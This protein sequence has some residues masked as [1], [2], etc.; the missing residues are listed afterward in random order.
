MSKK[1]GRRWGYH[2]RPIYI[3]DVVTDNAKH[4]LFRWWLIMHVLIPPF[5]FSKRGLCQATNGLAI[6]RKIICFYFL[7]GMTQ[8]FMVG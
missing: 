4:I 1:I 3:L 5:D 2:L 7:S 8:N 6:Q